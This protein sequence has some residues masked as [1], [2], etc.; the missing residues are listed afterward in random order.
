M[1]LIVNEGKNRS[2]GFMSN[3]VGLIVNM[4]VFFKFIH[5]KGNKLIVPFIHSSSMDQK[6]AKGIDWNIIVRARFNRN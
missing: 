2:L 4:C 1:S 3:E 6:Y 5:L